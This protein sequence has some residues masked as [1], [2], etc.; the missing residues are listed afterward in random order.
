MKNYSLTLFIL[1]IYQAAFAQKPVTDV[2]KYKA[3]YEITWQIDSTNAESVESEAMELYIGDK[4]SRF[5]S[6]ERLRGDEVLK[7]R[8]KNPSAFTG[9]FQGAPQ[10]KFDYYIYKGVPE[11]K[12]SFTQK[13]VKDKLKYIEDLNQFQWEILP[14]TKEVLGYQVQKA[15]TSFSGRD[16]IAWFTSEIPIVEGPYKFNGLPGL[17]LE[18]SDDQNY[19]SFKLTNFKILKKPVPFEY[20][21]KEYIT[22]TKERYL[23]ALEEYNRDPFAALGRAGITFGFQPGQ[24]EKMMKEHKE[25]L[26]KR[27]NPIELE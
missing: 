26:L 17:I 11:G 5:S 21:S 14:E 3:T 9:K 10:T 20:N 19:Y 2:F 8:R 25:T 22:T 15:T 24:K 18:I 16:Y 12:L 13:I 4:I 7:N 27:N 23:Q 6:K 1:I